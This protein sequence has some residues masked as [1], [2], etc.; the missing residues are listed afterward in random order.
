MKFKVTLLTLSITI[1]ALGSCAHSVPKAPDQPFSF[2]R[3]D[4]EVAEGYTEDDLE[5]APWINAN[6]PGMVSKVECPSIKDDFYTAANYDAF[7]DHQYGPFDLSQI[8]VR[9]ILSTIIDGNVDYPNKNLLMKTKDLVGAGCASAVKGY[10]DGLDFSEFLSSKEVFYGFCGLLRVYKEGAYYIVEF[11]DGYENGIYGYQTLAYFGAYSGY[12]SEYESY[13]EYGLNIGETL[14]TSLGYSSADALSIANSGYPFIRDNLL[15]PQ[16]VSA[17][18]GSVDNLSVI[19]LKNALIDAGLA[20]SSPIKISR[21]SMS[22]IKALYDSLSNEYSTDCKNAIKLILAFEH[23]HLLGVER[24]KPVSAYLADL[25]YLFGGEYDF[26][27]YDY[28]T[29]RNTLAIMLLPFIMEKAYLYFDGDEDVR[30]IVTGVIEDVLSTYK[31]MISNNDWLEDKSKEAIIKKLDYMDY[32]SCY[33]D[34]MKNFPIV[35]ETG[36]NSFTLMDIYNKYYNTVIETAVAGELETNTNLIGS[37]FHSYTVNAFYSP[38]TN[39]FVILNG[40]LSGGFVDVESIEKTYAC[41]GTVIG[42]EISHAFDSSGAYYNEYGQY[43]QSGYWSKTDMKAFK[44]KVRELVKFYN[45]INLYDNVYVNGDR[46]DGEATADMG[47]VEVILNLAK[48]IKKFDYDEF[49]RAYAWLWKEEIY[50]LDA[51]NQDTHPYPYL[52]TNI[53]LAQFDEFVKTYHLKSCDGMY[54][55]KEERVKIW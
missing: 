51:M 23:R 48:K 36:Y 55:P 39:E 19:G 6:I 44:S 18:S 8:N 24:Y 38:D 41:V 26:N 7:I 16:D 13:N 21:N 42:H 34:K 15:F 35:N 49:F 12:Y 43:N 27:G 22:R 3:L 29:N 28:E 9:D 37:S 10:I 53:T 1:L 52:R 11:N 54:I 40:L 17:F 45:K 47:A 4:Y 14:F 31:E 33:S 20:V 32:T 46:I 30:D 5:G 2:D 25:Y 50:D